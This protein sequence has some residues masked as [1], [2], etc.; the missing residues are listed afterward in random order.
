[1]S[2]LATF[3]YEGHA[4]DVCAV[5]D[6]E[7]TQA[8]MGATGAL[9]ELVRRH[10]SD[11]DSEHRLRELAGP[12][13]FLVLAPYVGRAEAMRLARHPPVLMFVGPWS[14]TADHRISTARL[15]ELAQRTLLFLRDRP[16]A[17]NAE[18]ANGIGVTYA[19]QISR[20]LHRLADEQLIVGTRGGRRNAWSLTERG[21][22]VVAELGIE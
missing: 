10:L 22:Q 18:I 15:T 21:S 6:W 13:I 12:M 2:R 19:S 7:R 5:G 16:L 11:R 4:D 9:W 17:S 3:I 8:A 1:M 14:A 20:H